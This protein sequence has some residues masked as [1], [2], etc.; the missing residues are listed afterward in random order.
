M[1][2]NGRIHLLLLAG[3]AVVAAAGLAASF[4]VLHHA[5]T[6]EITAGTWTLRETHRELTGQQRSS[7]VLFGEKGRKLLSCVRGTTRS[8][9][10]RSQ[11]RSISSRPAR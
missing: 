8:C 6:V 10:T 2:P 3:V 1:H 5:R 11:S 9:F 4:W 7:R